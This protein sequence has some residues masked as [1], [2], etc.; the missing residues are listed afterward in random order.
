MP[1]K[2]VMPSAD[3][4]A[5]A[6]GA[7]GAKAQT[8]YVKGIDANTDAMERAKSDASEA[9]Y[10]AGVM[11]A[12][13]DKS[14]QKALADVS[15]E[16][17]KKAAKDKAPRLGTGIAAAKD[18][19]KRGYAPIRDALSGLELPDK[20]TDPYANVDNILKKVITTQRKAA[21]KE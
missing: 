13:A 7:S 3:D 17:W 18:K 6:Y 4:I 11:K 16:D 9:N 2:I 19:Q 20:T 12:A 15:Q 14:R 1:R 5:N 10:N 8:A 21:G